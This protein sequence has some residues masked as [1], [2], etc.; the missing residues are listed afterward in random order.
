MNAIYIKFFIQFQN[1]D[2]KI[3]A[4]LLLFRRKD[5]FQDTF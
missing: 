5:I 3:I 1:N 4:P 2:Q